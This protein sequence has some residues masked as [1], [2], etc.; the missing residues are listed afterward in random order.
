MEIAAIN[1]AQKTN[2]VLAANLIVF[3]KMVRFIN[4]IL[5]IEIR[6]KM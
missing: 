4:L 3:A 6:W 5:K 2:L 1:H